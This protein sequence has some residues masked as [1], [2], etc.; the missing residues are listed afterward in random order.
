MTFVLKFAATTDRGRVR[1]RNE[2][3]WS[4]D[5]HA[6]LFLVAD[7]LGGHPSGELASYIVSESLPGLL[8]TRSKSLPRR[9]VDALADCVRRSIRELSNDLRSQT[10]DTPGLDGMGATLVL[11]LVCQDQGIV[12]HLGDCR[13]YLLRNGALRPLT[14]DHTLVQLLLDR[15]EIVIDEAAAHPARGQVTRYVGMATEPLPEINRV[16]LRRPRPLPLVQRRPDRLGAGAADRAN[17]GGR[18]IP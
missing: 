5:E 15:Q 1:P 10:S 14:R 8:R 3:R 18:A 6:G 17:H 2:D 12:A 11:L 9:D 4:A 7:G 16:E 13:G